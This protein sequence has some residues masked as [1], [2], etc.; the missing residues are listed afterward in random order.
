MAHSHWVMICVIKWS[1]SRTPLG[2]AFRDNIVGICRRSN[3]KHFMTVH[4]H[5][6]TRK[7]I[8]APS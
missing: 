6:M 1:E 8:D 2:D 3:G 5:M 4:I 7:N